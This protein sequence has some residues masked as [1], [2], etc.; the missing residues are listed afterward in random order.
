MSD[1]ACTLHFQIG[2]CLRPVLFA[3]DVSALAQARRWAQHALRIAA[4]YASHIPALAP[5]SVAAG[6]PH[7]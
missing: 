6:P 1:A 2:A 3:D 7:H 4:D 5:H